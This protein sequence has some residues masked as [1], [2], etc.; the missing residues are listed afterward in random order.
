[1][2]A[3]VAANLLR[4][5]VPVTLFDLAKDSNVPDV[6]RPGI[7][8]ASWEESG[9]SLAAK[10]DVVITALPKPEHVTAAFDSPGGILEGI[11]PGATWIEHSTTDFQNTLR[12]K[13]N[14]EKK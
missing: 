12:I 4:N 5:K 10:S 8:K 14:V 13:A 1:M 11:Q 6:L 2:G 9:A 7:A 3:A